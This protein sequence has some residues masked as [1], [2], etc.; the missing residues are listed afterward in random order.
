MIKKEHTCAL[1]SASCALNGWWEGGR[2]WNLMLR[3]EL[4]SALTQGG[5]RF[6]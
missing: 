4:L 5:G 2:E 6:T 1:S 3:L